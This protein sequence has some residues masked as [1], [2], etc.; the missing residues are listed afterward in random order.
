MWA[1]DGSELFFVDA[2]GGFVAAEVDA[3]SAFRVLGSETLFSTEGYFINGG[4]DTYDIGP[5][6][7]RFLMLRVSGLGGDGDSGGGRFI[8]VLNWFEELLERMGEN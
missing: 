4:L 2:E 8:L 1:H 6:D 3:D 5:D 7:E